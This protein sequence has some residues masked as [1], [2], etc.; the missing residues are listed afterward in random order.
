MKIIIN[1][2]KKFAEVWMTNAD[3]NNEEKRSK[4]N[5]FLD[6]CRRK[7]I[8]VCVYESGNGDLL[9]NAKSLLIKNYQTES[10]A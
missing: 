1:K 9:E 3:Q 5:E 4:L 7:E 8:Y 2:E 10:C 6:D